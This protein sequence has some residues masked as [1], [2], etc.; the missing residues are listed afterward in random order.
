MLHCVTMVNTKKASSKSKSTANVT[1]LKSTPTPEIP[2]ATRPHENDQILL[3][4]IRTIVKNELAAHEVG[5][6]ELINSNMKSTNKRLDKLSTEMSELTKSLEHTQ[7]QL[8]DELK[9]IKTDIKDLDSA[10]KEIEQ[11]I[12]EY[13]NINKKLIE[14]DDRSRKNNIRIDGIVEMP[15]ETWEECEIKVQEMFKMK[16]GIEE[17]IEIDR[18][19][20]IIPKKKDLTRP[21]TIICRLT[22]SKEKQKI[23]INAKVLIDTGIFIYKDYCKDIMRV[24]KRLWE[25]VLN[26]RKQ[27]KIAYLNYR[28]IVVRNKR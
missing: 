16:M 3:E 13:P 24:R 20:C 4:T 8:H 2:T 1:I 9:T 28:I 27:D 15:N 11:K 17:N 7:D 25:Q 26:Y 10:V 5:I 14:L 19:H 22:K 21:R 12:E 18:C 6:K 23:L